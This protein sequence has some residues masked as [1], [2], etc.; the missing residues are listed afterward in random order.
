M[1]SAD[2]LLLLIDDK[3]SGIE[4]LGRMLA[5]DGYRVE[6][7]HDG[8]AA[9]ERLRRAPAPHV[10]V[11]NVALPSVADGVAIARFARA[12]NPA[13]ALI[14]ITEHPHLLER[15]REQ[16]APAPVVLTKPVEY[17]VF[18]QQLRKLLRTTVNANREERDEHAA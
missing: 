14:F 4:I 12:N 5:E 2:T 8:S 15:K 3:E 10:V 17:R 1:R 18:T 9:L 11:T 13:T 7:V 16:L 6:V